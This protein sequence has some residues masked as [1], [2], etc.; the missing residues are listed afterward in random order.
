MQP[1]GGAGAIAN[2][3]F[4]P[5]RGQSRLSA[6]AAS[7]PTAIHSG[8][9]PT[10]LTN[11]LSKPSVARLSAT[12][13]AAIRGPGGRAIN[14]GSSA[15]AVPRPTRMPS[16]RPRSRWTISRD[17][18]AGNPAAIAGAGGDFAVERHGPF[19]DDPGPPA[20]NPLQIRGIQARRAS[21]ARRPISTA[22]PA[23]VNSAN[24]R[25]PTSGKGSAC[26]A[27]TRRDASG[28][29]RPR[30]RGRFAEMAAGLERDEGRRAPRPRPR[31]GERLDL[32]MCRAEL[33][34]P[35][36][37]DHFVLAGDH[38]ADHRIGLDEPFTA[39]GQFEGPRHVERIGHDSAPCG[40]IAPKIGLNSMHA[41]RGRESISPCC[42]FALHILRPGQSTLDP[43]RGEHPL[44]AAASWK[45]SS[46][47]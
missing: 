26:A 13:R 22:T 25:P 8:A 37:A 42:R 35:A 38:A 9:S 47:A 15:T 4:R 43:F 18:R 5:G 21:T 28:D 30:A 14:N 16:T 32:G 29:E 2:E 12:I 34:M 19:G 39:A 17:S 41:Q 7:G 11:W 31:G 33:P 6:A 24:P 23:A 45:D 46:G 10:V 1:V 44:A 27:T 20:E 3:Q 36:F 40:G